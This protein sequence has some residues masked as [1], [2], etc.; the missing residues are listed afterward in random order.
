MSR[1]T[2]SRA[3]LRTAIVVI[4][5]GAGA[6]LGLLTVSAF[7]HTAPGPAVAGAA[8]V[9]QAPAQAEQAGPG[10]SR[11]VVALKNGVD[12]GKDGCYC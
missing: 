9:R 4:S 12:G 8:I 1:T 3:R 5:V 7:T 6:G 11:Y 10:S 2:W